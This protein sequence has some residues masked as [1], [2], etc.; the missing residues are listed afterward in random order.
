MS[1][2]LTWPTES[3]TP[4]ATEAKWCHAGSNLSLDFH[5]DPIAA[6]LV[7]FSDG[8]HHMA[9]EPA[10]QSFV[11]SHPEVKD[12]FYATT[13]PGVLVNYLEQGQLALGNLVLSQ[14]PHVF[15]SPPGILDKLQQ[16]GHIQS[17]LAFMQSR[18][19]VLLVR[20]GNPK[21]I[22]DIKDLLR[23]D[24]RLFTSNPETE[25]ASYDVYRQTLLGFADE[26]G[27]AQQDLLSRLE[28]TAMMVF[29][30]CIHHREA[31]QCLY[32]NKAD[33]TMLYYHLALRYT[34]IFPE[35]F[36]IVYLDELEQDKP[37]TCNITTTYHIGLIG[38]GGKWGQAF[39]DFMLGDL[40]ANIYAKHGLGIYRKK[41]A[42][43]GVTS[44]VV[45][46]K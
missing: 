34:R 42:T 24:V 29:G 31:P 32:E 6:N 25:T 28:D 46:T 27:I 10:L 5:G 14:Q 3:A 7:V 35:S 33:V 40:V 18:G 21:N 4:V 2:R 36:E 9:L 19:N 22:H 20:K 37:A 13:P 45:T 23:D 11:A 17:H 26:Q 43:C 41:N 15:I 8:N 1:D 30:E 38:D 44:D 16:L 39:V 12:I